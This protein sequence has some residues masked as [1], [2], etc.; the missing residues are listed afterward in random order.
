M[1]K[2][3]DSHVATLLDPSSKTSGKHT[4]EVDTNPAVDNKILKT[5]NKK[6]KSIDKGGFDNVVASKTIDVHSEK[7]S[8]AD[9]KKLKKRHKEESTSKSSKKKLKS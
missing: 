9:D 4:P 1:R 5:K 8:K 3:I 7:S 2:E 6:R